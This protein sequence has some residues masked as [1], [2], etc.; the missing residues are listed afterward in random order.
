MA[1]KDGGSVPRPR[2]GGHRE[3]AFGA[4][5]PPRPARVRQARKVELLLHTV[6]P[7]A[8][9][10]RPGPWDE[11]VE[12][13]SRTASGCVIRRGTDCHRHSSLGGVSGRDLSAD[14]PW[15]RLGVQL[16]DL[17][18]LL[19]A[20]VLVVAHFPSASDV[21]P[22]ERHRSLRRCATLVAWRYAV[23]PRMPIRHL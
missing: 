9:R 13:F 17:V 2:E 18:R 7:E 10:H 15:Q 12:M 23:A 11:L 4:A 22:D 5:P 21:D 16:G 3:R 8:S 20:K 6:A 14:G 1:L 19:G